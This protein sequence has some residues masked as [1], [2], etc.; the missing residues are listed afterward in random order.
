MTKHL[1]LL[2]II[3]LLIVAMC[4]ACSNGGFGDPVLIDRTILADALWNAG[5]DV[6][7]DVSCVADSKLTFE[8]SVAPFTVAYS[9]ET[10]DVPA[11]PIAITSDLHMRIYEHSWNT[12][13][14]TCDGGNLYYVVPAS[15]DDPVAVEELHPRCGLEEL[16]GKSDGTIPATLLIRGHFEAD[17][18]DARSFKLV[19]DYC[20]SDS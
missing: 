5:I 16:A 8:G 9:D 17:D 18:A 15:V 19:A 12:R 7:K 1:L 6:P 10:D 3:L 2:G 20:R 11:T 14:G 4:S 13:G